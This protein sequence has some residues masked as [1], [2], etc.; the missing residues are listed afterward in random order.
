MAACA[1]M[2]GLA[3]VAHASAADRP[4]T[5]AVLA[6]TV[7]AAPAGDVYV[8]L[9]G[10]EV[11][12]DVEALEHAG[13]VRIGGERLS[14]G[15]RVF[16]RLSSI[17]PRPGIVLD[18]I[19]LTLTVTADPSLFRGTRLAL[20]RQRPAGIVYSR[21]TS[22]FLNYG[23]SWG[24][25]ASR[26]VSL[27][28]GATLG[29]ALV[30]STLFLAEGRPAARGLTSLTLD[31]RDRLRRWVLGDAVAATGLLG[32]GVQLAGVSVSRDF[33]IDP[34]FIRFPT[35]T[36]TGMATSPS[37]LEVYVNNQLVRTLQVQP[38]PYE[39]SDVALPTG[40][41]DTRVVVRDA[42]GGVQ[43][44]GT[45]S[46]VTATVLARGLHQYHYAAG[47]ERLRPH[48]DLFAYGD[49]VAT[50]VHRTGIT[51]TITAGGRVEAERGFIS[52]G[53]ILATKLWRAGAV[54]VALAASRDAGTAGAAASLAYEYSGRRGAVS[55]AWRGA[56]EEYATLST[57]RG[58][59]R[60]RS[61]LLA[62][63]HLR[64][65]ARSTLGVS[66]E[67]H[68]W[69]GGQ[70]R[71]ARAGV[72]GSVSLSSGL[73]L[74]ASVHRAREAHRWST[75][76]YAGLSIGLGPRAASSVAW[77]QTG[78]G[79]RLVADLQRAL[80]TG[81][82]IGY[83]VQASALQQ[84]ADALGGELHAQ[85]RWVQ[86]SVHQAA[87]GG[88]S[89]AQVSG[90][91]VAI[92]GRVLP[93]RPVRDGF[94]LVRLPGIGN[95]RAY[96][97][98]QEAGRTDRH[99]DLLLPDLL[100]YY[101]NVISIA[102]EDVPPDRTLATD[103]LLLA[104]PHRGGAIVEFAAARE[105]RATGRIT[106]DGDPVALA[107]QRALDARLR[108]EGQG[109]TVETLLGLDGVFYVEGLKPGTYQASLT[110][111]GGTCT[112]TL[113]IPASDAPVIKAGTTVCRP[114]VEG[115]Q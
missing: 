29:P 26:S 107:G 17:E 20:D 80:P 48:T 35:A 58:A 68:A 97:S 78:Q 64:T 77:E 36:L 57:R 3:A 88:G 104:P 114:M 47:F 37:R 79:R 49:P 33:S 54:E 12:A 63:V 13:L 76:A 100:A 42:F 83:R 61:D 60:P 18:P 75:S 91:V 4:F 11:W 93:S 21:A 44:L 56:T 15:T 2:C 72:T 14:R 101:G 86:A 55:L 81:P 43:E 34:Y 113:V 89:Y 7:N 66:W 85:T 105:W 70:P 96:V 71:S 19:E 6:L 99:G 82:G 9:D 67:R 74:F 40:A 69:H 84:G 38:G 1:L 53:P 46:Y 32:G 45:S 112:A 94:A 41:S 95:V 73:S 102:D 50:A 106:I 92:G 108:I 111:G 51:D 52:A 90:A 103:R 10:D 110:H 22:A 8:L 28:S 98:H 59:S 16:V 23:L 87:T 30:T 24:T 65:S 31:D 62:S 25:G 109:S 115:E 27:E 39:L 5:P